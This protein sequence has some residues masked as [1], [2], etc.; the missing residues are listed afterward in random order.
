MQL[1]C[2]SPDHDPSICLYGDGEAMATGTSCTLIGSSEHLSI[3][4]LPN[5][6]KFQLLL[7]TTTTTTISNPETSQANKFLSPS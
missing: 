3:K 4:F 1:L 5:L 6:S 2:L 7:L